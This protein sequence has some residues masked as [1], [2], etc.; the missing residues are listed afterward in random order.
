VDAPEDRLGG[1]VMSA[2]RK[3]EVHPRSN[4]VAQVPHPDNGD[5]NPPG[6]NVAAP[7]F[8]HLIGAQQQTGRNFETKRLRSFQ[9]D[10]QLKLCRRLHWQIGWL[11]SSEN[12]IDV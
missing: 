11:F 12:A 6:A 2:A 7:L 8:D 3:A 1:A 5:G 9:I 4:Y 10:Y